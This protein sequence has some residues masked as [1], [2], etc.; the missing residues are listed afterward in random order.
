MREF[1]SPAAFAAFLAR[2]RDAIP[3]AE[4]EGLHAGARI[5][6]EEIK[7]GMGS[8]QGAIHGLPEWPD[9]AE[10]TQAERA[11]KGYD[12]NGML[13]RTGE[14]RAS[15]QYTVGEGHASIGSDDPIAVYQEFGTPDAAHPIPPRPFVGSGLFR[16]ADKAVD[17]MVKPVIAALE[18]KIR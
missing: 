14:L 17:A 6:Q 15:V 3:R 5:V 7:A 2:V 13:V 12:P 9:L 16:A 1:A 11:R 10:R 8:A 18:G 4:H